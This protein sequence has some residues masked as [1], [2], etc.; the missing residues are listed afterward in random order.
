MSVTIDGFP[1]RATLSHPVITTVTTYAPNNAAGSGGTPIEAPSGYTLAVATVIFTNPDNRPVPLGVVSGFGPLPVSVA[2]ILL[3]VPLAD[4]SAFGLDPS[5]Q[6]DPCNTD[7]TGIGLI[8][9]PVGYC[10]LSAE[11]VRVSPAQ[12]GSETL[13]QV[14]ASGSVALTILAGDPAYVATVSQSAPIDVMK[15]FINTTERSGAPTWVEL[16]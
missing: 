13:P 11:M 3:A 4:A 10:S 16:T 7:N 2:G 5:T 15:V 6:G 12:T 14:P 1:F 8:S 9:A